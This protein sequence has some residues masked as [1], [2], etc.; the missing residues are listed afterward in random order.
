MS[1]LLSS[2]LACLPSAFKHMLNP[3]WDVDVDM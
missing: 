3:K 1:K 2:D